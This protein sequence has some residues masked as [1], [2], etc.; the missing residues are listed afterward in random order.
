MSSSD[1]PNREGAIYP[2]A[3]KSSGPVSRWTRQLFE[4]I[5]ARTLA[6]FRILFGLLML[7]EAYLLPLVPDWQFRPTYALLL[8]TADWPGL[9]ML[10]KSV[11]VIS[12]VLIAL[13]L[14]LRLSATAFLLSFVYGYFLDHSYYN[15]HSYLIALLATFFIITRA[16][17][18]WTIQ[19]LFGKVDRE[20][21]IP[22]WHLALFQF[23]L[24]IVY[25]YGGLAKLNSD[26][27]QAQPVKHWMTLQPES[28]ATPILELPVTPY[29]VAYFGLVFDVCIPFILLSRRWP[30]KAF[31][32]FAAIAFHLSNSQLF[33][34]G[35]FPWLGI[36]CLVLF[37]PLDSPG[38]VVGWVQRRFLGGR[39]D[40]P[41]KSTAREPSESST[42]AVR[43][44]SRTVTVAGLAIFA[45][46]Q[47]LLPFRH[48]LYEGWTEW[49]EAG[50]GFSWRMM[51]YDKQIFVG[52]KLYD[53]LTRQSW[54]V[55]QFGDAKLP[56]GR[57][58]FAMMSGQAVFVP[59]RLLTPG[60]V[61]GRG[62]WGNPRLLKQYADQIAKDARDE[63]MAEPQIFVD[64]VCSLNGRPFQYL[65]DPG[66]DLAAAPCPL[67][68]TP[69]YLVPLDPDATPGTYS[70]NQWETYQQAMEVI[71][72][73]Q[74]TH[75]DRFSASP[76]AN[77]SSTNATVPN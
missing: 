14:C 76:L 73:H 9:V 29:F 24:A 1:E 64:A 20:A 7:Q 21:T 62:V 58:G 54:D 3:E 55:D 41:S 52:I 37:L 17:R 32:F 72:A 4:P 16:D 60:Q 56:Q 23:Q 8:V 15:N 36:A 33:H 43:S 46:V 22:R 11:M 74:Q 39:S 67:I 61:S 30:I 10:C 51:L 27:L 2:D 38:R 50:R 34:I 77:T 45:L 59:S 25:F 53:P 70:K 49:N 68:G 75:P 66:I 42:S 18:V 28:I 69:P 19:S 44:A 71:K 35:V 31:G 13:G 26:W 57:S 5:D 47:M 12:A 65:I 6:L 63:G 40:T 48:F